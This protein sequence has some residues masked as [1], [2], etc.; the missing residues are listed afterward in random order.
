MIQVDYPFSNGLK[1][2]T[3]KPTSN[4]FLSVNSLEISPRM[5]PHSNLQQGTYAIFWKLK[6]LSAILRFWKF[7]KTETYDKRN[8]PLTAV[9]WCFFVVPTMK[10]F[11]ELVM[12]DVKGGKEAWVTSRV[13]SVY[14]KVWLTGFQGEKYLH[15]LYIIYINGGVTNYL[16]TTT[17]YLLTGMI[18]QVANA[19]LGT[20]TLPKAHLR[21]WD[22]NGT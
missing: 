16:L 8:A 2:P 20:L 5:Q 14:A 12:L 1:P 6:K 17:S 19:N 7:A 9:W 11:G 4:S 22:V 3:R 18:L 10:I 13:Y 15:I 21:F